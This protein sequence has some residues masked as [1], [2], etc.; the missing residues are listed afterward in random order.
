VPRLDI[1]PSTREDFELI[2]DYFLD[3]DHDSL[4]SMGVEPAKLPSRQTWMQ[5]FE[6]DRS[7]PDEQKERVFV[8][9]L[10]DGD[11]VG[12]SSLNKIV[13]R[14]EAFI[15]LHLWRRTLRRSG[16]GAELFRR[17]AEYFARR[18]ELKRILC[19]PF[20]DNPAPNRTLL[21][22]GFRFI[23]RRRTTPGAIN[24]EQ[25]VNRYELTCG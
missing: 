14:A 7:L 6:R 9:W 13:P 18:F 1:R 10:V 4:R 20:A 25:D 16:L 23:E 8:T 22:V 2:L 21:K 19:E 11:P 17:S 12:H 24:F 3:A 5:S 15:H